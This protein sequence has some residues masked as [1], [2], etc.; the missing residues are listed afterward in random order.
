MRPWIS[1]VP[2]SLPRLLPEAGWRAQQGLSIG[3]TVPVIGQVGVAS[4]L[5]PAPRVGG[6]AARVTP[7]QKPRIRWKAQGG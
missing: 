7:P 6:G 2:P 1:V 4:S 5:R 3:T